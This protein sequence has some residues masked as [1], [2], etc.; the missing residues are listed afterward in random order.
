MLV[1]L[2]NE[3]FNDFEYSDVPAIELS[4]FWALFK[5]GD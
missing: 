4:E 1:A 2:K 3:K 5:E